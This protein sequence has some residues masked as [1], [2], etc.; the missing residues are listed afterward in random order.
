MANTAT[1]LMRKISCVF[2]ESTEVELFSIFG[3]TLLGSQYYCRDCK[4]IF[5][6]V[7]FDDDESEAGL[8]ADEEKEDEI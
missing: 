2:C 5:E 4:S 3:Q 1:S 7:R 8:S 6:V